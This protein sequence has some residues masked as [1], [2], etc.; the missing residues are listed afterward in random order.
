M[1][2]SQFP[3][4]GRGPGKSTL[5]FSYSPLTVCDQLCLV[6][7]VCILEVVDHYW[8]G[9]AGSQMFASQ[10]RG[11]RT[12]G[13]GQSMVEALVS[14]QAEHVRNPFFRTGRH[15]CKEEEEI[16]WPG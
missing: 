5:L 10:L 8:A 4:I 11:S 9:V 13:S 16:S 14:I 12:R 3:A 6:R 1:T 7:R 15:G 2:D